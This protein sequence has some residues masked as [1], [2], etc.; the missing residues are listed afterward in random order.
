MS[1]KSALRRAAVAATILLMAG[2][3]TTETAFVQEP[4][5][6]PERPALPA[7]PGETLACLT[8]DA[9]EALAVRDA[10]LQGHVRRLE[11]IIRT[12]HTEDGK[13]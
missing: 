13:Q 5:P 9:Y 8:D 6:L 4:L 1:R 11:A 7:L 10:T 12:T 2:C 3:A